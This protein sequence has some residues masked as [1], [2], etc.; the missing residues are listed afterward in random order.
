MGSDNDDK[1]TRACMDQTGT[2][3]AK[4]FKEIN[5]VFGNFQHN[6]YPENSKIVE[7]ENS[8]LILCA[9]CMQL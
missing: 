5:R 3:V 8:N 1:Y 9:T 7:E 6:Q 4:Q 2:F